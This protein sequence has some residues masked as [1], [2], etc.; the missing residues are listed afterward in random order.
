MDSQVPSNQLLQHA[1][2]PV[3]ARLVE[4]ADVEADP[5]RPRSLVLVPR[6][7]LGAEP[8]FSEMEDRST[9]LPSLSLSERH[10]PSLIV[11]DAE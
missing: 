3:R 7:A 8:E 1:R 10:S 5:L 11:T 9:V 2:A 6:S 4:L